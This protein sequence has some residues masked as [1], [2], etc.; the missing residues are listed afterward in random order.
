MASLAAPASPEP[1]AS[2]LP[3]SSSTRTSAPPAPPT[4]PRRRG[5]KEIRNKIT[6]LPAPSLAPSTTCLCALL[7]HGL[8]QLR[9]APLCSRGGHHAHCGAQKRKVRS[10]QGLPGRAPGWGWGLIILLPR[11][12]GPGPPKSPGCGGSGRG[13]TRPQSA[14]THAARAAAAGGRRR[15]G[16]GGRPIA[17]GPEHRPPRAG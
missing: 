10:G 12:A 16:R 4:P 9:G 5:E 13:R 6:S 2:G 1:K 15:S 14:P 3:A 11:P 7:P 8:P 17:V